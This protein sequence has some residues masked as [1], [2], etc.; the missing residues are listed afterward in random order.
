MAEHRDDRWLDSDD[1]GPEVRDLVRTLRTG[2]PAPG[3][4]ARIATMVASSLA[5]PSAVAAASAAGAS[6]SLSLLKILGIAIATAGAGGAIY[7]ALP[8]PPAEAPSPPSFEA[9]RATTEPAIRAREPERAE[10]ATPTPPEPT[11]QPE[12]VE[13]R[14]REVVE[15]APP[16]EVERPIEQT[17][18]RPSEQPASIAP[19]TMPPVIPIAPA[20]PLD[21]A[22]LLA[23][24]RRH[25]R[26]DPAAALADIRLH[27]RDFPNGLLVQER[28]VLFIEVLLR[29]GR[30]DDA[31]RLAERFRAAHPGS[32]LV[33]R[34]D[35]LFRTLDSAQ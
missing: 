8:D 7:V 14:S 28:E 1:A 13:P 21:E 19:A 15:L 30:R 27:A 11:R 5:T 6:K 34:L 17:S 31:R 26:T 4:R 2:G 22:A 16:R 18:E 24:A 23:R 32:A 33:H 35:F 12:R 10:I 9:R 20:P 25:V 3:A 29:S